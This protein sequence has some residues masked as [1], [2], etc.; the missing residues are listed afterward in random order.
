MV[1]TAGPVVT[2]RDASGPELSFLSALSTQIQGLVVTH[3]RH[4]SLIF[5]III[6]YLFFNTVELLSIFFYFVVFFY[7]YLFIIL[8]FMKNDVENV[9]EIIQNTFFFFVKF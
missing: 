9:F 4:F 5:L 8:L 7:Y 6:I 2:H 3:W 1:T